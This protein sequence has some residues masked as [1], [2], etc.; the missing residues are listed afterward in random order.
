M[1]LANEC[2]YYVSRP[3]LMQWTTPTRRRLGAKLPLLSKRQKVSSWL[4]ADL[5]S[6]EIDFRFTPSFGHSEAHAGLPVLTQL[7]SFG[8]VKV[9][10]FVGLVLAVLRQ[11]QYGVKGLFGD[12]AGAVACAEIIPA[13]RLRGG[14]RYTL[15]TDP[16]STDP[17]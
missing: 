7:G 9:R 3:L 10:G 8:L 15:L 14:C 12:W 2:G 16:R 4:Q 5:Q 6:P 11:P 13:S 17:P 1:Q